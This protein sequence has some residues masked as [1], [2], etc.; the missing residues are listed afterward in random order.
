MDEIL[1]IDDAIPETEMRQIFDLTTS[2]NFPWHYHHTS[3]YTIE[4]MAKIGLTDE[5]IR[6][7]VDTPFMS[8]VLWHD[9]P[10]S[11]FTDKFLPIAR[12]IPNIN[13]YTI[14]RFK[15]NL[16]FPSPG[17]NENTHSYPH[18]DL[19]TLNNDYTTAIYYINDSVG[20]TFIFNEKWGH[21]GELTHKQRITP[22]KGR[23][24]LFDGK[25]LHAGN[26][27]LVGNAGRLVANINLI[28]KTVDK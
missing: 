27:P 21:F 6:D 16:T 11:S 9:G 12:A 25:L 22:K 23:L 3:A 18:C 2:V 20:D 15:L 7:S 17:C 4:D 8:H 14:V 26:N 13:D 1:I 24:V 19:F 10:N 5:F 28:K